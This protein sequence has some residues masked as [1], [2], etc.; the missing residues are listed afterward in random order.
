M[1]AGTHPPEGPP[2]CI[3]LNERPSTTPPPICS[4]TSRTVIPSGTSISPVLLTFPASAKT[5]VPRLFS[6][7]YCAYQ[8][9]PWVTIGAMLAKLS[10]LL[11][12]VGLAHRPACAG[13][14]GRG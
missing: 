5:L 12:S 14:G 13:Y 6:V 2:V 8:A 9:P 7:P 4:T 11:M 3:A 10:T 1:D